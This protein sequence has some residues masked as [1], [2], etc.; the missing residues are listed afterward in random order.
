MRL[1][2]MCTG[3]SENTD[4]KGNGV[5]QY[6][7]MT[8]INKGEPLPKLGVQLKITSQETLHIKRKEKFVLDVNTDSGIVTIH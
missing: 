4:E 3:R 6:I 2:V 8:T 7:F 5:F 1:K